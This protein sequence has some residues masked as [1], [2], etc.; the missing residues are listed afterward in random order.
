MFKKCSTSFYFCFRLSHFRSALCCSVFQL[1]GV[2]ENVWYLY[3]LRSRRSKQQRTEHNTSP[4]IN[5]LQGNG[6][7]SARSCFKILKTEE[8]PHVKN[9]KCG[10]V[11]S[12]SLSSPDPSRP[13]SCPGVPL[14]PSHFLCLKTQRQRPQG[15]GLYETTAAFPRVHH[16]ILML[17]DMNIWYLH[18]KKQIMLCTR[19]I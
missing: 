15:P 16:T 3:Q 14:Q 8:V 18:L 7:G 13:T 1:Y 10:P 11:E 17:I 4:G 6:P 9:R 19:S 5:N 2:Q 12:A